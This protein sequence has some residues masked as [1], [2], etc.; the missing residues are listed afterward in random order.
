[1]QFIYIDTANVAA[2]EAFQKFYRL[3]TNILGWKFEVVNE[4]KF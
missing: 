1:M 2:I 4:F 3:M